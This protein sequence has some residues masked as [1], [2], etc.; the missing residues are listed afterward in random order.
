MNLNRPLFN[1]FLKKD[2]TLLSESCLFCQSLQ[3]ISPARKIRIC[4]RTSLNELSYS[5]NHSW[6]SRQF[7]FIRNTNF[8]KLNATNSNKD[9]NHQIFKHG[10]LDKKNEV[11]DDYNCFQM[12]GFFS[13]NSVL[14]IP[15]VELS[16]LIPD[17]FKYSV[18]AHLNDIIMGCITAAG[19]I[20]WVRIFDELSRRDLISQVTFLDDFV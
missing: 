6:H 17:S 7:S 3:Q 16:T 20:V 18:S 2:C 15:L 5:R 1:A 10:S 12:S 9:P 4:K 11:P 8:T 14:S 13:R 19:A